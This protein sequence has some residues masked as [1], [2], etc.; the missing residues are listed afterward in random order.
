[1]YGSNDMP[2]SDLLSRRSASLSG[3]TGSPAKHNNLPITYFKRS[4]HA[5]LVVCLGYMKD[6]PW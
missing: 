6:A 1:M 5:S 3:Y 4:K 2:R